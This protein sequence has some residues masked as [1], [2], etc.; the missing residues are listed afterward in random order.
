MKFKSNIPWSELKEKIKEADIRISD[1]D[2]DF[3]A[4]QEDQLLEHLA[5]I[6][7]KDVNEVRAWVESVA[8]TKGQA[9]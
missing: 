6:M 8:Y 1:E 2:L 9:S 7:K 3:E 5:H 4:G